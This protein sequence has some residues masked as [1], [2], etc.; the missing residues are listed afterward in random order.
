MADTQ[1]S[2]HTCQFHR[3]LI[4]GKHRAIQYENSPCRTCP[5]AKKNH[6]ARALRGRVGSARL[7]FDWTDRELLE[8]HERMNTHDI[9][10]THHEPSKDLLRE[11]QDATGPRAA[12]KVV[13]V[14]RKSGYAITLAR[15]MKEADDGDG[16][17]LFLFGGRLA[18]RELKKD[19]ARCKMDVR[20]AFAKLR[21]FTDRLGIS[22]II[23]N[24]KAKHRE[25]VAIGGI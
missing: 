21:K 4:A 7:S 25:T 24:K 1:L 18:H 16:V 15:R 5:L 23:I 14:K 3:E 9:P 8:S 22:E 2:C 13:K 6:M 11:L 17:A 20:Y 19:A 10:A 12:L